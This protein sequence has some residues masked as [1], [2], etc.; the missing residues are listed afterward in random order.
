[1]ASILGIIIKRLAIGFLTLLVVTVI[2]FSALELLP[3]DIAT[4]KLGQSATPETLAAFR[5]K[6]GLNDPA[7]VRYWNW[8]TGA[9][10]GDFG[11]SL[12]NQRPIAELISTRTFNTLFLAGY[13]AAIAVPFAV[14][15]GTLS[16]LYRN[17]FLD[18]FTSGITSISKGR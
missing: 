2:I 12:A 4:E 14:L 10:V 13:A 7:P 5:E 9:L 8:L 3:G 18:R 1:M 11:F 16:A 17:S 15:F 6:M